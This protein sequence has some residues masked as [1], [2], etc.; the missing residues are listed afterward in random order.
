VV[1][2][3]KVVSESMPWHMVSTSWLTKQSA[4]EKAVDVEAAPEQLP[5]R[6]AGRKTSFVWKRG[7][8]G[9]VGD[10]PYWSYVVCE[11]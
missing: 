7:Y 4:G 8:E 1:T 6:T 5:L 2:P 10:A 11:S 9:I 3:V